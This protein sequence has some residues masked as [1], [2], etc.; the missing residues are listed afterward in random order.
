M[1][2]VL[3]IDSLE[4]LCKGCRALYMSWLLETPANGLTVQ[5]DYKGIQYLQLKK[6]YLWSQMMGIKT[7]LRDVA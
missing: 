5:S 3:S 4:V 6:W 1:V 7:C 2:G